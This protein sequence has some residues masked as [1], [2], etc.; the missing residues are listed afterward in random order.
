LL[1][2]DAV[3]AEGVFQRLAGG[4]QVA[5]VV[6]GMEGEP[7]AVGVAFTQLEAQKLMK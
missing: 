5:E 6:V 2:A 1:A 7:G 3:R 4:H